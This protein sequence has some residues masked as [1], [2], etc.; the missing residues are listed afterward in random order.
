MLVNKS[1]IKSLNDRQH[2]DAE[3][4]IIVMLAHLYAQCHYAEC[5]GAVSGDVIIDRP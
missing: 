1:F 5:C 3:C 4:C 2:E